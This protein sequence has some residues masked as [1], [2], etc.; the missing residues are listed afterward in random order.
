MIMIVVTQHC[1]VSLDTYGLEH[2]S[3]IVRTVYA[4]V[5]Q[6]AVTLCE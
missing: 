2:L 4:F 5:K 6:S 3:I 1:G